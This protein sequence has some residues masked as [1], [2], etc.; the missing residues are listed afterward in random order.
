MRLSR[1]I[2]SAL[3]LV[4]AG[5]ADDDHST[6]DGPD[7]AAEDVTSADASEDTTSDVSSDV[8]C[9]PW[10]HTPMGDPT[11]VDVGGG[12]TCDLGPGVTTVVPEI[13]DH[14]DCT[15]ETSLAGTTLIVNALVLHEPDLLF[16]LDAW[17][18]GTAGE[19]VATSAVP[20][21]DAT[22][23]GGVRAAPMMITMVVLLLL[24]LAVLARASRS[25][26]LVVLL[27]HFDVHVS[28]GCVC[29]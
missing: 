3:F 27:A 9:Q 1:L 6:Q 14:P 20:C 11:M 21:C 10:V 5:C 28:F 8:A 7:A 15:F 24:S 13:Q 16:L 2:C 23:C 19:M 26:G 22:T 18:R 12:E 17:S 29:G 4:A 25:V